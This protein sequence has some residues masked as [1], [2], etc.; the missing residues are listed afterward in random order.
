MLSKEA[1]VLQSLIFL[2]LFLPE[3][4]SKGTA[5]TATSV[6]EGLEE[7]ASVWHESD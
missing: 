6:A 1:E 4:I 2:C 3:T 5:M 7:C